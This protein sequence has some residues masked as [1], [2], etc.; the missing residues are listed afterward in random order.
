MNSCLVSVVVLTYN[1]ADYVVETLNSVKNQSYNNIEL[2]ISDDASLDATL[3]VCKK[4]IEDNKER[5]IYAQV[6][7]TPKNTGTVGNL[8]RAIA[9]SK[10]EWIKSIGGDDIL[11]P[12]AI[13]DYV[14]YTQTHPEV[15]Q[16][17]AKVEFFGEMNPHQINF[18]LTKRIC[19]DKMSARKQL[20]IITKRFFGDGPSYFVNKNALV[21]VGAYDERFPLQEDYPLF[22]RMIK[23]G[24][25]MH[26]LDKY[27]ISYRVRE[28]SVSHLSEENSFFSKSMVRVIRDYRFKYREE[29][30]SFFWKLMSKFSIFL[31]DNIIKSGNNT[32]KSICR[33]FIFVYKILDPYIWYER[34]FFIIKKSLV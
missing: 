6:I 2:L 11:K 34:C 10:G 14:D 9:V 18:D 27:T 28:N 7:S 4:W 25:K 16:V 19:G 3:E 30:S 17:V 23:A 33:L 31:C 5:F 21:N 24:Y 15:K 13:S 8:N 1:S 29:N 12:S 20:S 26:F 22:I 32:Q